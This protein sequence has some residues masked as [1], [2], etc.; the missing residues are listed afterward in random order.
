MN[1]QLAS[2]LH[3]DLLPPHWS[4]ETLIT[5]AGDADVLVLAGDIHQ[6]DLAMDTFASW[7]TE[8]RIPIIYVAGNHECYGS[9]LGSVRDRLLDTS[10]ATGIH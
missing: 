9:S 1:I 5:P 3:L 2:D 8:K 6:G 4:G 7:I 10:A